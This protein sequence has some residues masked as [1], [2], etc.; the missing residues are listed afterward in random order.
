MKSLTLF[1]I[2]I[3]QII[4]DSCGIDTSRDIKTISAR[5]ESEGLSFLTITLPAFCKD[6]ER[7]LDNRQTDPSYFAGFSR[8]KHGSF[9]RF[10][11][12]FFDRIFDPSGAL[13]EYV[14]DDLDWSEI[15][16]SDQLPEEDIDQFLTEQWQAI[17]AVRQICLL[18][19]KIELEAS[20]KRLLGTINGYISLEKELADAVIDDDQWSSFSVASVLSFAGRSS[21]KRISPYSFTKSSHNTGPGQQPTGY[22]EIPNGFS[23]VTRDGLILYFLMRN[24]VRPIAWTVYTV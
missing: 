7:S 19:S 8:Q 10:L 14:L 24:T 17:R 1:A 18:Y 4:G 9:P 21:V 6:F 5:I 22:L 16:T 3:T 13:K 2:E 12:G 23:T 15:K 20:R 11:G